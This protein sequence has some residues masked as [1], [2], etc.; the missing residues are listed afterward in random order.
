MV[1]P[2]FLGVGY[3]LAALTAAV[4]M[5]IGGWRSVFFVGVVPAFLTFWIRRNVNEPEEWQRLQH[6]RRHALSG[7]AELLAELNVRGLQR[8]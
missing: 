7:F 8:G 1:L 3:A 2:K 4:V 5:P 6:R